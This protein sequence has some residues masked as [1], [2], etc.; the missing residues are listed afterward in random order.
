MYASGNTIYKLNTNN[1]SVPKLQKEVY[2]ISNYP[3]PF[4]NQTTMIYTLANEAK[5]IVIEVSNYGSVF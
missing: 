4:E 3:N 2:S 1:T 5:E